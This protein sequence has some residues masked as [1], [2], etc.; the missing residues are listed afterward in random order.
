MAG[1]SSPIVLVILLL[2]GVGGWMVIRTYRR[3]MI[4]QR[5]RENP[6]PKALIEVRL[7][8]DVTDGHKSAQKL[9]AKIQSLTA[10][11]P[12][13]RAQ[14]LGTIDLVFYSEVPPN[15]STAEVWCYI[16]CHPD[17]VNLLKRGL[18][19]VFRGMA[20]I[21]TPETDPMAEIAA[22][23]RPPPMPVEAGG[24]PAPEDP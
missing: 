24:E 14:G 11:D 7:P 20:E 16:Y 15:K 3:A 17:H 12:A 6:P 4:E 9:W 18:R 1:M 8:R 21:T 23:L 13:M 19:Q 22:G 5:L 2:V 10:T